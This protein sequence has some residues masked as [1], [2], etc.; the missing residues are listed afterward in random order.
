MAKRR[1]FINEAFFKIPNLIFVGVAGSAALVTQSVIFGSIVAGIEIAYIVGVSQTKWF[2]K[3]IRDRKGWG[4]SLITV[5]ERAKY[6]TGLTEQS[7]NRYRAFREKYRLV[8]EKASADFPNNALIEASMQK[9]ETLSD[10]YLKLLFS[11]ERSQAYLGKIDS[12]TL[13]DKMTREMK[14]IEGADFQIKQM[15]MRN[16]DMLNKRLA[17]IEKG[18]E[19]IKVMVAQID[20]IEQSMEMMTDD[21]MTTE[22]ISEVGTQIDLMMTN[23][24]DANRII[25][26]M[27]SLVINAEP[28][29]DTMPALLRAKVGQ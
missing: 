17:K 26:E 15:R 18:K 29:D 6:A 12:K 16:I 9:L 21:M 23:M 4:G 19:N 11:L 8:S 5:K 22:K 14:E 28:I 13:Q 7:A 2:K 25:G 10:T 1:N 27:D 3:R 20:M 24:E